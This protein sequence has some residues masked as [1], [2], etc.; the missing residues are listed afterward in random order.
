MKFFL[1]LIIAF[2]FFSCE[3]PL[4]GK[5]NDKKPEFNEDSAFYFIEKQVSF[6]PRIPNTEAHENCGFFL[7]EKLK[8][9]NVNVIVQATEVK[10]YKNETLKI[11]NLIAEFYPEKEKR[12]ML[13]AHWDSRPYSDFDADSTY[14]DSTF[15]SANDGASGVGVLLE[16]A[17]LVS[18]VEPETGVDVIFF[19]A[20]DQGEH[21][22]EN[23]YIETS[24]C[25]GSQYWTKN[26][27]REK[28]SPIYCILIDLVGEKDA[29]F[30]MEDNSRHFA[31]Y[32]TKKIWELA[33][34]IGYSEYF[35]KK[36]TS[37]I[38]HDH[39]FIGKNLGFKTLIITDYSDRTEIGYPTSWHTQN[40][41]MQII[42]K[43]TLNAVGEVLLN[44]IYSEK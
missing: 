12:I 5:L 37:G 38:L 32:L 6:G 1:F 11:K 23:V 19:D 24:W 29:R 34:E 30:T 31:G 7:E 40:D 20:E 8:S 10:N 35:V 44:V 17:R 18:N 21:N 15:D 4:N 3:I 41:N 2:F 28:Y 33:N 27:H 36:R 13:F 9:F 26:L 22:D 42:D 16:I 43:K 39:L 14:R 25:L